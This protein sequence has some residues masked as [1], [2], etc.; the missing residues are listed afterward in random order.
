SHAAFAQIAEGLD[1]PRYTLEPIRHGLALDQFLLPIVV[2]KAERFHP[3]MT[4]KRA[5]LKRLERQ[6]SDVRDQF[7][8]DLRGDEFA[9]IVQALR[10][11]K[12]LI[13]EQCEL[14]HLSG[15]A[16]GCRS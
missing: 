16:C 9:G 12:S 6:F 1:R 10:A 15:C 13:F 4:F 14:A 11:R 8:L 7:A 3:P 5:E 2:A